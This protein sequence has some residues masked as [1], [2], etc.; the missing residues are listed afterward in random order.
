MEFLSLNELLVMS[1][2]NR[3]SFTKLLEEL[4]IYQLD[5]I[6]IDHKILDDIKSKIKFSL[7][8][9]RFENTF[10]PEVLKRSTDKLKK[11]AELNELE[12]IDGIERTSQNNN[13]EK[14][15]FCSRSNN[16]PQTKC[17]QMLSPS[18]LSKRTEKGDIT[19]TSSNQMID[20]KR[21]YTANELNNGKRARPHSPFPT[22]QSPN[23]LELSKPMANRSII[24]PPTIIIRSPSPSPLSYPI[25][26]E[27]EKVLSSLIHAMILNWQKSHSLDVNLTMI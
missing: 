14:S 20:L 1:N 12:L 15:S 18:L 10:A 23:L 2:L 24:L 7:D 5:Q 6:I 4:K 16:M 19:S 3:T 25:K 26:A 9:C 22:K 13:K 27:S 21:N 11:Q 8:K 17:R